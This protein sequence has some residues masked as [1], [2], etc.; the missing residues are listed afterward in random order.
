MTATVTITCPSDERHPG[1]VVGCGSAFESVPDHEGL[2]DCPHC[3]IF[4]TTA[5]SGGVK[6]GA[7]AD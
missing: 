1:D 4:F 3:G 2:H 7:H 6:E 5:A